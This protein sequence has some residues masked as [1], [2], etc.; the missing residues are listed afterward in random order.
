VTLLLGNGDGTFGAGQSYGPSCSGCLLAPGDFD[1]DG[2]LDLALLAPGQGAVSELLLNAGGTTSN[3]LREGASFAPGTDPLALLAADV[4]GDGKLDLVIGGG[5]AITIELGLGNGRFAAP[6]RFAAPPSPGALAAADWNGDGKLDLAAPVSTRSDV[7]VFAGL[8]G[9]SFAPAVRFAVGQSP[10]DVVAADFDH[11]GKVD[12]AVCNFANND[13][14][15]LR[16][17][18]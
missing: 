6:T 13:I 4:D 15:I 16:N 17:A 2:K 10:T 8:G 14:G 9:G 1:G 7:A 11:D 18:R 12:L 3:V 5:N